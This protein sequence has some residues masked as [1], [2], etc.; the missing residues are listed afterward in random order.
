FDA[1]VDACV[2]DAHAVPIDEQH[3]LAAYMVDSI[4]RDSRN[5]DRA[6]AYKRLVV[7][8]DATEPHLHRYRHI[9]NGAKQV[10]HG[11]GAFF[12][13]MNYCR[14]VEE[15]WGRDLDTVVETINNEPAS[16][17]ES[18]VETINDEP[19]PR[20]ENHM[21]FCVLGGSY[22]GVWYS[23]GDVNM[24]GEYIETEKRQGNLATSDWASLGITKTDDD[25]NFKITVYDANQS[26]LAVFNYSIRESLRRDAERRTYRLRLEVHTMEHGW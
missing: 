2:L 8:H 26:A 13:R 23:K 3:T 4:Y 14:A 24:D 9:M 21:N 1:R 16:H 10:G 11:Q 5:L 20:G 19:V 15:T 17:L 22:G 7:T 18:M 12:T 6:T 25:G